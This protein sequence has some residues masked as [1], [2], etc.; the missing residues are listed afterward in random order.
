[1]MN[2]KRMKQRLI[3]MPV[4]ACDLHI[5]GSEVRECAS[6]QRKV[7]F[8]PASHGVMAKTPGAEIACILCAVEEMTHRS[9]RIKFA[10]MTDDQK[11][12]VI[13]WFEGKKP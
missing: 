13:A 2:E 6:C 9:D 3:C 8:S 10:P 4:E 11:R 12:E 1:M 7:W 5:P